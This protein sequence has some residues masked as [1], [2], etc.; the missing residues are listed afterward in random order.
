[1]NKI[2][3]CFP[4]H[5]VGGVSLLFLRMAEYLQKNHL[6]ECYLVDY[7]DGFMASHLRQSGVQLVKY[8]DDGEVTIPGDAIAV[9]Q[10]MTPWSIYP[11]I[12]PNLA[13]RIFYWNCYPFNLVPLL[14]AM[15]RQMQNNELL[16]SIILSTL[17]RGYRNKMR[18]LTNL[19]LANKSLVFMDSTNLQTTQRY[20][21]LTVADPVYVPIPAPSIPCVLPKL[22]ER[23]L[24]KKLRVVWVGRVV[25]FKFFTLQRALIELNRL[26]PPLSV[27][28][29][30]TIVGSGEYHQRL[31]EETKKLPNIECSFIEHI[32]PDKLDDFL[33]GSA[34]L[35]FAMGTSAMEGA[36]LGIPT[37]LLDIANAPVSADYPFTWLHKRKGFTLGDMIQKDDYIP[38]NSSLEE[39][40]QELIHD[41]SG[42]SEKARSYIINNHDLSQVADKLINA[43]NNASCTYGDL[44][45]A[46][47]LNRGLFYT[48]F[49]KIRKKVTNR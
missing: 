45:R 13:T 25:D 39:C 43:L 41:Y 49:A 32:S 48:L 10:S 30:M 18:K 4:Y 3:F 38:G 27:D 20:L 34:D 15:R 26:Q 14:P 37:I 35:L 28:I 36:R 12:K 31:S 16:S 21:G 19:L 2:Y 44:Q 17:L 47:M 9:F 40:I 7:T 11:A 23:D 5:G 46:G 24:S 8:T 22:L 6:A 29:T 42:L 33:I 1:M